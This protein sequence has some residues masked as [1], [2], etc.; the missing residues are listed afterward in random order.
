[1]AGI[2]TRVSGWATVIGAF[3][4]V[5]WELAGILPD[6]VDVTRMEPDVPTTHALLPAAFTA[7]SAL[8]WLAASLATRHR[9]RPPAGRD[10]RWLGAVLGLIL[11]LGCTAA[12]APGIEPHGAGGRQTTQIYQAGGGSHA[13]AVVQVLSPARGTGIVLNDQRVYTTDV[14]VD[15][16]FNDHSRAVSVKDVEVTGAV[17]PGDVVGVIYAPRRP[18][19]G[20]Q[21]GDPADLSAFF[22]F[23]LAI[24][25][26]FCCLGAT[27]IGLAQGPRL[28]TLRHFQPWLH[29]P[30]MAAAALAV[31]LDAVVVYTFPSTLVSWSLSLMATALLAL[32][33]HWAVRHSGPRRAG[34]VN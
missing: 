27:M 5:V 24:L 7:G 31:G 18:D 28:A 23:G 12:L 9:D 10:A 19:L 30:I 16:P 15:V 25:S 29:L 2:W 11:G 4:T 1:M 20:V 17:T 13:A 33:A 6:M 32:A 3:V 34:G 14:V 26:V 21:P 8:V 22:G